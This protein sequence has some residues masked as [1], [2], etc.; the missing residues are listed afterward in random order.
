MPSWIN[1]YGNLA[2]IISLFIAGLNLLALIYIIRQL[3]DRKALS[4]ISRR[5]EHYLQIL[6]RGKEIPSDMHK[7][8][9]V[10]LGDL[11]IYKNMLFNRK[12]KRNINDIM[13]NSANNSENEYEAMADK[14]E[15]ILNE[16]KEPLK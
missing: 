13:K 7:R 8:I 15:L 6:K 1:D 11:K 5:L 2:S 16:I 3:K 9:V 14:I 12:L 4:V 10:T